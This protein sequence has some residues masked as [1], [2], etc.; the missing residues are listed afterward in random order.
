MF[1]LTNYQG[2][3]NKNNDKLSHTSENGLYKKEWK[4]AVLAGMRWKR[5]THSLLGGTAVWYNP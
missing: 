4:Q 3:S 2:N 1:I 5:D